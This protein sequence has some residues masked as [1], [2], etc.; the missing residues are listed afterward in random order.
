MSM[1]CNGMKR[2]F[3]EKKEDAMYDTHKDSNADKYD[4]C[5]EAS[6]LAESRRFSF[7]RATVCVYYKQDQHEC[8][9]G[10]L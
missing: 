1:K 5:K 6:W 10:G 4:I 7:E 8:D 9:F 2:I 3:E